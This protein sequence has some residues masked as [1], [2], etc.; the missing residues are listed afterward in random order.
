[1]QGDAHPRRSGILEVEVVGRSHDVIAGAQRVG[2]C[3]E[4]SVFEVRVR[5]RQGL[6]RGAGGLEPR[7]EW[8]TR[9]G[10]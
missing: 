9:G 1:M 4:R 3:P 7:L 5:L 2:N 10:C 8:A 6:G